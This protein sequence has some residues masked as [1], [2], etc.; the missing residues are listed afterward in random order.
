[1]IADSPRAE[2]KAPKTVDVY[3]LGG[4]SNMQGVGKIA[5]LP[6]EVKKE[7]PHTFFW[8]GKTFEPL[9]L[10]T[11]KISTRVTDF[12]PEVGFALGTATADRPVYLI[13]YHA[14]GMPLHHG[15]HGD[16]WVGGDPAPGRRTFYPGEKADDANAGTLYAAMVKQFR[17]GVTHLN[18]QGHTPTV[19]G[20]VW[21]QG[22]ADAKQKESATTYA[23][24]LSRLR[25]RLAEDMTTAPALPFVFGQVLPHEPPAARFTHRKEIREQMAACDSAS[26]KPEAMKNA[27]MVSTDGFPLLPD[28]V[29]YDAAGQLK[30]GKA[31]AAAMKKLQPATP[32]K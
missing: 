20:F 1:V 26:K 7:I 24:S 13:K 15:W 31:F 23:A 28:T 4:Q 27:T 9:V 2:P 32:Q 22:E 5:D 8:N 12:G 25:K 29:H 10:G 18:E 3:L 16:K 21:M 14:S 6:A 30:L 17:A 19:R 11:T